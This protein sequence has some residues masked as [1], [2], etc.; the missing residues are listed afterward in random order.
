MADLLDIRVPSGVASVI[1]SRPP[2]NALDADAMQQFTPRFCELA[3]RDGVRVVVLAG[4][5]R[6][7]CA[8]VDRGASTRPGRRSAIA[9]GSGPFTARSSRPSANS[10]SPWR[11]SGLNRYSPTAVNLLPH[12][13]ESLDRLDKIV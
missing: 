4:D 9:R 11:S 3:E 5:G 1:F 13:P 8:G 10:P 12:H 2:A 6:T 7:F